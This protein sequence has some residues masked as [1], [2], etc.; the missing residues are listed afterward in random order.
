MI[1]ALTKLIIMKIFIK[2]NCLKIL[3]TNFLCL[4]KCVAFK[5]TKNCNFGFFNYLNCPVKGNTGLSGK[6][7]NYE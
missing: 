1:K 3:V 2:S 4:V 5:A 7:F 6:G